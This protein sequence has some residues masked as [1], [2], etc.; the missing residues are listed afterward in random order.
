MGRQGEIYSWIGGAG[1]LAIGPPY[2]FTGFRE[3]FW[4]RSKARFRPIA[5]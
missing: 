3:G 1:A 4:K 2:E 5:H